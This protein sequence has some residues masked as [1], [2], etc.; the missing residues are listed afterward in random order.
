VNIIARVGA[1]RRTNSS[2]ELVGASNSERIKSKEVTEAVIIKPDVP[3]G[4]TPA[5]LAYRS[6]FA[7]VGSAISNVVSS[8]IASEWRK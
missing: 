1:E 5:R 2:G 8:T 3:V 4:S 6:V 7:T